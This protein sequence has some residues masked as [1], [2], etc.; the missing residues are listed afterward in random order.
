MMLA[1]YVLLRARGSV[2]VRAA[3]WLCVLLLA[4]LS[5]VPAEFEV[6]TGIPGQIEHAMAYGGT[7]VLVAIAYPGIPRAYV[8]V[9]LGLYAGALEIGQLWVP[10]RHSAFLDWLASGSGAVIGTFVAGALLVRLDPVQ[11]PMPRDLL[12][13]IRTREKAD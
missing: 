7:A 5:L 6:R 1:R 12:E 13:V 10:G 11:S 8:V 2:L 9:G 4:Y 3:A